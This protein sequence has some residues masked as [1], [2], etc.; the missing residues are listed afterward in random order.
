MADDRDSR[1]PIPRLPSAGYHDPDATPVEGVPAAHTLHAQFS[2]LRQD[3]AHLREDFR[4]H[5]ISDTQ[6]LGA[7]RSTQDLQARDISDIRV[8]TAKQTVMLT[9]IERNREVEEARKKTRRERIWEIGKWAI[10][11]VGGLVI[12][13]IA[14]RYHFVG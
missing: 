8:E 4:A 9:N 13:W 3:F 10:V 7:I 5:S 11:S 14:Q 12:G 1:R 2:S 6:G